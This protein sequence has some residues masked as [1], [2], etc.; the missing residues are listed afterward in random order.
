MITISTQNVNFTQLKYEDI[1]YP[2]IIDNGIGD[3]IRF[4]QYTGIKTPVAGNIQINFRTWK[5]DTPFITKDL[6]ISNIDPRQATI[7]LSYADMILV[8]T[9]AVFF[10]CSAKEISTGLIKTL[11]YGEITIK[12]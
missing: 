5:E 11:F 4:N 12:K 6:I 2:L 1:F 8:R 10:D 3:F 7:S 9:N